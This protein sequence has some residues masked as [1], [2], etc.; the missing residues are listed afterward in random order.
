MAAA[1]VGVKQFLAKQ[2]PQTEWLLKYVQSPPLD[3]ILKGLLPTVPS[4]AAGHMLVP[5][6]EKALVTTIQEAAAHRNAVVHAG[7]VDFDG[8]WLT[9]LFRHVRRLLYLLDYHGGHTEWALEMKAEN[10]PPKGG[11][12][13]LTKTRAL[14]KR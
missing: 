9:Q 13:G 14:T 7:A 8:G 3:K 2:F 1:E 10:V 12:N 11:F 5:A 4:N 6:F